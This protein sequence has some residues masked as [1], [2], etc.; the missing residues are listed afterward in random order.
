MFSVIQNHTAFSA[1]NASSAA[2]LIFATPT[3]MAGSSVL[4]HSAASM[5]SATT[6]L[7]WEF[8]SP[9]MFLST[10][11]DT[12]LYQKSTFLDVKRRSSTP[13]DVTHDLEKSVMT[14]AT[15]EIL[16]TPIAHSAHVDSLSLSERY[17]RVLDL[18]EPVDVSMYETE[19]A[20]LFTVSEPLSQTTGLEDF[21]EYLVRPTVYSIESFIKLW[22]DRNPII[23]QTTVPL[24]SFYTAEEII[25]YGTLQSTA[26][27]ASTGDIK[28]SKT[29]PVYAEEIATITPAQG[30][31]AKPKCKCR[32]NC[33]TSSNPMA[34]AFT[35]MSFDEIMN[36][37]R[38]IKTFTPKAVEARG[39]EYFGASAIAILGCIFGSICLL[40]MVTL[41]RHFKI[42]RHNLNCVREDEAITENDLWRT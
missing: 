18:T 2:P 23:E 41:A 11:E 6:H 5:A 12:G 10:L 42:L 33:N 14:D 38:T 34:S 22:S 7:S 27:T 20:V 4:G 28:P 21:T 32:T 29:S 37:T 25:S 35:H 13:Q 39:A 30:T 17:S 36:M 40:D 3:V 19:S 31:T 26:V 1:E 15:I 9:R 16:P 8:D 24:S